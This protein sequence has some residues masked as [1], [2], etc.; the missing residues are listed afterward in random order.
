LYN[1]LPEISGK[2]PG[3]GDKEAL[4]TKLAEQGREKDLIISG[5]T[6]QID[7]KDVEIKNLLQELAK[8]KSPEKIVTD[9]FR[10]EVRYKSLSISLTNV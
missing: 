8:Y 6:T 5:L 1:G 7:T 9:A 4:N 2:K 3:D 10:V